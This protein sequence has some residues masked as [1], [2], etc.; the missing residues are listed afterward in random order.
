MSVPIIAVTGTK[1]KTTT[2]AVIADIVKTLGRTTLK[3]DTTGHFV[4]GER[5]STLDDSK[6]VWDL[7]PSV[8]PGR[9]LYEI[10]S[11]ESGQEEAIAILECALGCSSLPGLGYGHH[12]VGVFLNVF[13]DHLG[14]SD[15]LQTKAD[16]A[17]AK[18]FIFERIQKHGGWAVFNADDEL[19][20]QKL[21]VVPLE[22][23]LL[24][25]GIEFSHFNLDEHLT[26]GGAVV[27][28]TNNMVVLRQKDGDTI[29]ADLTRIPWTF[30][31]EFKPSVMNIMAAS[32]AVVAEYGG[33]VSENLREA[34]EAVRLDP[35]G[36]RLTLLEGKNGVTILADYAHEKVSLSL[37]GD[38]A[39]KMT[40]HGGKVIGVVRLAHDRTD[41]LI[42]ETAEAIAAHYDEFVVYDKIDGHWR[43]PSDRV[44][45]FSEVVGRTSQVFNDALAANNCQTTRVVRED[46]AI[47]R[48]ATKATAGDVVVVIVNDDIRRSIN[49]IQKSFKAEII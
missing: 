20:S 16:I 28:V 26:S 11:M 34:I 12:K 25:F 37:V 5:R 45:R 29:L 7:V 30:D 39:R 49:F 46:E 35:Y 23:Q 38:L 2:V 14:S 19:I 10:Q 42:R 36:G 18:Q 27:T 17:T 24:P 48:A 31:G 6:R 44:R 22:C 33:I 43:V 13:E 4:N 9:Y 21:S 40:K 47:A 15:R 32:A 1:G 41:E 3:V 8:S